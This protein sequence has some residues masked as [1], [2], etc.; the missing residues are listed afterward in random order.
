M[1]N[2]NEK[3]NIAMRV[4]AI[5]LVAMLALGSVSAAIFAILG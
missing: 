3:N 5:I 1:N 2:K 4:I